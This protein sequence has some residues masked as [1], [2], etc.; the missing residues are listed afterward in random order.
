MVLVRTALSDKTNLCGGSEYIRAQNEARGLP[1][2][3]SSLW[4]LRKKLQLQRFREL[5]VVRT[6]ILAELFE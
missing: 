5:Y 2:P 4:F 1:I 3:I 6:P